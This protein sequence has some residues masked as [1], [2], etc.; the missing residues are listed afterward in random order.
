MRGVAPLPLSFF[1][2][3]RQ[4]PFTSGNVRLQRGIVMD[5]AEMLGKAL[6]LLNRTGYKLMC[7]HIDLQCDRAKG[8][9]VNKDVM[10]QIATLCNGIADYLNEI[11]YEG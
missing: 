5:K 9:A 11:G 8:K 3:Y 6:D 7:V 1:L 2:L 4:D 10:D